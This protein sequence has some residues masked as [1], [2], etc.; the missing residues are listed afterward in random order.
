MPCLVALEKRQHFSSI[1]LTGAE[2][3][4]LEACRTI[5]NHRRRCANDMGIYGEFWR[6]EFTRRSS[7]IDKFFGTSAAI[8]DVKI[9]P[10]FGKSC[11]TF[12]AEYCPQTSAS[13]DDDSC[14]AS[15]APRSYTDYQKCEQNENDTQPDHRDL[16]NLRGPTYEILS[17]PGI[18]NATGSLVDLEGLFA[19]SFEEPCHA[20]SIKIP[21][22]SLAL[23]ASASR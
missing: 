9:E 18:F 16:P 10:I 23:R 21:T 5:A 7:A 20:T 12:D 3:I 22:T 6:P 13:K 15:S 2:C 11:N 1:K 8:Q 19:T 4:L 17:Q 14:K